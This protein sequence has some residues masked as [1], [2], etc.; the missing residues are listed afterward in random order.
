MKR[1]IVIFILFAV[2]FKA[3]AQAPGNSDCQK[4]IS[5]IQE[6][7]NAHQYSSIYKALSKDF[8]NKLSEK[9]FSD[10]LQLNLMDVYG[11]INVIVPHSNKKVNE[12]TAQF[13][14]GSLDLIL[15]CDAKNKIDGM[16]WLPHN[17]IM[18][19][20]PVLSNNEPVSDNPKSSRWDQQVDSIV[21]VFLKNNAFC[22]LSIGIYA[23][24]NSTYYNYGELKKGTH[25]LPSKNT[26]YEIGSISKTFTGILFANA[27][28]EKKAGLNDP[29]KKFLGNDYKNLSYKGKDIELVHLAN[30]TSRIQRIP[31]DLSAQPDF[32]PQNPYKNYSETM[33]L[34]YLKKTVIDTF[35]GV[36]NEY[37]NLGMTTLAVIM[38][39]IYGKSYGQLINEKITSVYRLHDTK[40]NYNE[41]EVSNLATGY[42]QD[43]NETRHWELGVFSGAGGIRSTTGDLLKFACIN[44]SD[45]VPS[46][47][48]AHYSTFNDSKTNVGLAWQITNTRQGNEMIWHNGRTG[49]FSSFCGMIKSK[50]I[51]VVILCNTAAN[52]DQVA[53]GILKLLQLK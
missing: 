2:C 27:I 7:F 39:K 45:T 50:K 15:T 49:G 38:E 14:N 16:Q 40:L 44:L 28:N 12:Y 21:R 43:G 25:I 37:S 41:N 9:E 32:D 34:D 30:H 20:P 35:P 23:N 6:K 29:V 33:L 26:I 4:N 1:R 11:K 18:P 51:A 19:E 22:G 53:L 48:L 24:G 17:E 42:S 10:F 52:S 13:A 36:K 3:I 46:L 5:L 8:Q 47:K 31:T